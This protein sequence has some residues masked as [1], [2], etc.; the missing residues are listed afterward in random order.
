MRVVRTAGPVELISR[1]KEL[2]WIIARCDVENVNA[3]RLT[4]L[5]MLRDLEFRARELQI[6]D[7]YREVMAQG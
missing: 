6:K 2:L 3:H 4:A 1:A 5:A 7:L